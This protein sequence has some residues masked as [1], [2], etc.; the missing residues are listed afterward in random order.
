MNFLKLEKIKVTNHSNTR[1]TVYNSSDNLNCLFIHSDGES[2]HG[3]YFLYIYMY[4]YIISDGIQLI[5][6]CVD[7]RN[8]KKKRLNAV[9]I[10]AYLASASLPIPYI[11]MCSTNT[12]VDLI[13]MCIERGKRASN[14]YL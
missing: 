13:C 12:T 6:D 1:K 5:L 14:M 9:I 2:K 10:Y 11:S 7:I 3:Y 8:I 4:T